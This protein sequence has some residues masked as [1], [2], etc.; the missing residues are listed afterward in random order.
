MEISDKF[1]PM[2]RF[3]L[4]V[5]FMTSALWL[6][7]AEP[8][9]SI[10]F[11]QYDNQQLELDVY[12]PSD[13]LESHFCV[14][15]A[16]GG[17]FLEN[18]QRSN[19]IKTFCRRLADDGYVAVA[20][21]YRLGL[22]DVRMKGKLSMVK[23][24]ENAVHMAAED[25]FLAVAC[26]LD[27]AEEWRIN[28]EGI[29]LCGS[30]AGAITALQTDYEL[31]NRSSISCCLPADFNFAGVVSFAGAVFSK[32]GK[33]DYKVQ[34][35][36]PTLFLHGTSD[37]MVTY[38]KI[39]FLNTRFSG[40]SDLVKRFKKFGYPYEI[41]RYSGEGHGVAA[42]YFDSYDEMTWFLDNV[43]KSGRHFEIDK[44][45][46]DRDRKVPDWSWDKADASSMYK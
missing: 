18:N 45:V 41:I 25:M 36:A 28:P 32:E 15:Y 9:I 26:I 14:V 10:P 35:P 2:K 46:L 8:D 3:A 17:G 7:A 31:C 27:N 37:K 11:A 33:C 23:P 13:T 39:A 43:V 44:L 38:D 42:R 34:S 40:S 4:F 1:V 30:S 16:Y 19:S 29:I 21:D 22:K 20:V 6:Y 24:L 12:M 5:L